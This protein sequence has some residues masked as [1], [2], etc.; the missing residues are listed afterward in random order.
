MSTKINCAIPD[1][2]ILCFSVYFTCHF[3]T[4]DL[5]VDASSETGLLLCSKSKIHSTL[6]RR[7]KK[8]H[9]H[10][11]KWVFIWFF[12]W[13]FMCNMFSQCSLF[14]QS[15]LFLICFFIFSCHFHHMIKDRKW[16]RREWVKIDNWVRKI[17]GI[18][19]GICEFVY[20]NSVLF[21]FFLLYHFGDTKIHCSQENKNRTRN[22]EMRLPKTKNLKIKKKFHDEMILVVGTSGFIVPIFRAQSLLILVPNKKE[23][24]RDYW[25]FITM[26]TIFPFKF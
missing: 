1:E 13:N 12:K 2:S 4:A 10:S 14:A 16:E 7:F 18:K 21:L 19:T 3:L 15:N 26:R 25:V 8:C 6:K 22:C 23:P 20:V 17:K 24:V 11:D 9:Q 5:T